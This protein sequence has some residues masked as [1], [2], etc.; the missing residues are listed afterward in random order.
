MPGAGIKWVPAKNVKPYRTPERVG[1]SKTVEAKVDAEAGQK[2]AFPGGSS[3]SVP[4][5]AA[6]REAMP[7]PGPGAEV[8]RKASPLAW[9]HK[10]LKPLEPPAGVPAGRTFPVPLL[11]P[12]KKAGSHRRGPLRGKKK[13]KG[14]K[15][16]HEP[17]NILK[18]IVTELHKGHGMDREAL[19]KMAFPEGREEMPGTVPG[20]GDHD[21]D[22]L[23]TLVNGGLKSLPDVGANPVG[24]NDLASQPTFRIEPPGDAE[25]MDQKAGLKEVFPQGSSGSLAAPAAGRKAMPD[26]GTGTADA[27]G[28]TTCVPDTH[29]GLGRDFCKGAACWAGLMAGLLCLELVLMLCCVRLWCYWKKKRCFCASSADGPNNTGNENVAVYPSSP[30]LPLSALPWLQQRHEA[31]PKPVPPRDPLPPSPL[32]LFPGQN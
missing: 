31:F 29:K 27:A 9:L 22:Y 23:E 6:G 32:V 15:K 14:Q 8:A 21:L 28:T 17:N 30:L 11:I 13:G 3:G 19:W 4:A 12:T 10:V 24:E 1:E 25:V 5:S 16:L 2:A 18:Q 7:G 20:D 26:K